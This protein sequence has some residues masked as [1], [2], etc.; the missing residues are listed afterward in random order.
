MKRIIEFELID[1]GIDS[2]SYFSEY[3][4]PIA[5]FAHIV[6]GIGD[7]LTEAV[8]D[9]LDWI[10]R[11]GVNTEGMDDR[12][13]REYGFLKLYGG[14]SRCSG[15]ESFECGEVNEDCDACESHYYFS[16]RYNLGD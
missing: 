3:G 9:C 2:D 16:I 10:T 12:I 8:N 14:P 6:T 15:C 4:I 1:H 13:L 7:N 11:G 5:D